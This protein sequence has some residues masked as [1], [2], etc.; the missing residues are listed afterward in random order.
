MFLLCIQNHH[1]NQAFHLI[2][3]PNAPPPPRGVSPV[4]LDKSICSIGNQITKFLKGGPFC[5]IGD[6]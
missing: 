6:G 3:V 1:G 2:L 5:I 4:S